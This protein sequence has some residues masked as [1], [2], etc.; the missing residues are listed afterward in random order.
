MNGGVLALLAALNAADNK[1][2][3]LHARLGRRSLLRIGQAHALTIQRKQARMQLLAARAQVGIH[4]PVFFRLKLLDFLFSVHHHA[5]GD[6]LHAA[7]GQAFL[8]LHPEQR[9]DL[10]AHQP[11]EHAARL[12][13]VDQLH[14]DRARLLNRALD[15]LFGNLVKFHAAG[16]LRVDAQNRRQMPRNRFSLAVRVRRENDGLRAL[17]F[18]A[19][20]LKHFAAASDGDVLRLKIML[21]VHAELGFGQIPHV[22][23]RRFDLV[24]SAQKL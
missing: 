13:G 6:G 20:A 3:L 16:A 19:D 12:L 5:R 22:A 10:V 17:R 2:A 15:R 7:R 9:A 8:D 24:A 11:V 4:I 21:N 14:I 1:A 18:L 23:L